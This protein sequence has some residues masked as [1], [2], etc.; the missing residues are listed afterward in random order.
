MPELRLPEIDPTAFATVSLS[1]A[2]MAE[3]IKSKTEVLQKV[4]SRS[5]MRYLYFS[6]ESESGK[7]RAWARRELRRIGLEVRPWFIMKSDNF[8]D[9]KSG[10]KIAPYFGIKP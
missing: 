1:L 7:Q 8:E 2:K 4:T 6:L 3:V 9:K 5:Y 10:W